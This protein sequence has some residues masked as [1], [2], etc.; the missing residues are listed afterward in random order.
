MDA[1]KDSMR[2]P[3]AE[4]REKAERERK[5]AEQ[6]QKQIDEIEKMPNLRPIDRERLVLKLKQTWRASKEMQALVERAE[7]QQKAE[8]DKVLTLGGIAGAVG[9]AA[10][11][12][13]GMAVAQADLMVKNPLWRAQ[14][15]L[16][17][18]A[19]FRQADAQVAAG[20]PQARA[21]L[22]LA[23]ADVLQKT[24]IQQAGT[25]VVVKAAEGVARQGVRKEDTERVADAAGQVSAEARDA[26]SAT[27]QETGAV[28]GATQHEAA[29]DQPAQAPEDAF[30]PDLGRKLYVEF[31]GSPKETQ[32]LRELLAGRGH[33]I[34]AGKEEAD[35][36]YL[37]EGEYTIPE[38]KQYGGVTV[39]VGELLENPAKTITP[40]EN[41]LMGSIGAGISKFFLAAAA[42]QGQPVPA[43]AMPKEG[44]F[45]QEVLLV[46][47]RQP[48]DGKET[49][50][51]V[52]EKAES[53]T[54][55][56][57]KLSKGAKEDLYK[58]LGI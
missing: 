15:R 47:A 11:S 26:A 20:I 41:K 13:P 51:S 9:R 24:G 2:D 55:E 6:M 34:V 44:V 22:A 30:S 38:T 31:V 16:N 7:A 57:V 12:T 35:V 21:R 50:A 25:E 52:V 10:L 17:N 53:A 8:R 37:I 5:L 43:D 36:I 3:E 46:I 40:P 18:E 54:I 1:V 29:S 42:A 56:A 32:R 23:Q 19:V 14:Q 45:P 33:T 39:G 27:A 28:P 58:A 49:R 4:A 48:K